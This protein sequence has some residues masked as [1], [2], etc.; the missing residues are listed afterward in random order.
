MPNIKGMDCNYETEL[1]IRIA[2]HNNS[3]NFF[4]MIV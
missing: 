2:E 3:D 4:I 1:Y